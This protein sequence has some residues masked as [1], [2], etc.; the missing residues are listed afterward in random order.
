MHK[1]YKPNG[2]SVHADFWGID[3][4]LLDDLP[5]LKALCKLAIKKC[6]A[7]LVREPQY[8]KF[9]PSGVTVLCMLEES[10]LSI[11]TYPFYGFAA[12]DIFTCGL[13]T[14]PDKAIEFIA[15]ILQPTEVNKQEFLRG[16]WQ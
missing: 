7:T 2:K 8:K 5:F 3:P 1:E 12:I 4:E 15:N 9:E 6:G 16:I 11:H 10:H 13:H 14:N